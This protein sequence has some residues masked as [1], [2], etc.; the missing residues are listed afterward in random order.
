MKFNLSGK[1]VRI[2]E[3]ILFMKIA[4]VTGA[5]SGMGR[6][7]VRLMDEKLKSLDEIWVVARRMERLEEL[8]QEVEVPLVPFEL[9]LEEPDS[10]YFIEQAL[11]EK[12]PKV[13]MLVNCAGF[14]KIGDCEEISMDMALGMVNVNCRALTAVTYA[15]IP[16]M[17]ENSRI[18]QLASFAAFLPQPRFAVYAATK[19]YVL[20]FSRALN[21]ELKSRNI[22]VT[23]VCPGP[24]KT[25]FFDIAEETGKIA[26]YKRFVMANPVKVVNQA[27]EDSIKRK[28]VSVYGMPMRIL[29]VLCKILPHEWILK[30]L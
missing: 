15:A 9:D 13:K 28:S 18:I 1:L 19:S 22:A 29:R 27:F 7:F 14:G 16:Y 17:A 12:K 3:R 11:K 20:S 2:K 4:I 10:I 30:F 8:A 25:E 24:V 23:A 5:S 6:E 26:F 21:E